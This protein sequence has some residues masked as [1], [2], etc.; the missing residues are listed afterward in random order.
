MIR[1]SKKAIERLKVFEQSSKEKLFR[2]FA[3]GIG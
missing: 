2:I 1:I 3:D